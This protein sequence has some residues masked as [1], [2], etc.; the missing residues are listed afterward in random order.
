MMLLE[1]QMY[2][3]IGSLKKA[4]MKQVRSCIEPLFMN[5]EWQFS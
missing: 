2:F 3:K 1:G 4:K 5:A